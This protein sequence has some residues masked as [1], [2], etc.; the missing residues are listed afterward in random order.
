M[1]I[2]AERVQHDDGMI[3]Y[4][5]VCTTRKEA[6]RVF[7]MECVGMDRLKRMPKTYGYD[8]IKGCPDEDCP[9]FPFRLGKNPFSRRKGNPNNFRKAV[10]PG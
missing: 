4:R 3:V 7:C 5:K 8:D 9:L 1:T 10:L 2:K 6:I